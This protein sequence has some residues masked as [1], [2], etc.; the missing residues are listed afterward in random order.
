MRVD[1]GDPRTAVPV[2][3][4]MGDDPE[5][6]RYHINVL[7]RRNGLFAARVFLGGR[8]PAYGRHLWDSPDMGSTAEAI[9]VGQEFIR[10]HERR[11]LFSLPR[12][13]R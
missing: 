3:L 5:V 1:D 7:A 4:K 10:D 6:A 9:T 13:V 8:G 11:R 2:G 12:G